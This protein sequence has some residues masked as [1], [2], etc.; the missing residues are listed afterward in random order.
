MAKNIWK[1]PELIILVRRQPAE[2]ILG[3][4]KTVGILIDPGAG[5]TDCLVVSGCADCSSTLDT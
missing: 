2:N 5:E 3:G 4:C 1:K